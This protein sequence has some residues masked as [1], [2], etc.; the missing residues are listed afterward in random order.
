MK[1]ILAILSVVTVSS[2]LDRDRA[3]V[4]TASLRQLEL[5]IVH[6]RETCGWPPSQEEGLE[7]LV[8]EPQWWPVEVQWTSYLEIDFVPT[9]GWNNKLIYVLDPELAEGFGI[10]SCGRDGV[11]FS[12]GNDEADLNTWGRRRH[13][14]AYYDDLMTR[15]SRQRSV[16]KLGIIFLAI[17]AVAVAG[18]KA[19]RAKTRPGA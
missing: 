16:I 13:W 15:E 9:D 18:G 4:T 19:V 12:N 14:L 7:V 6:F 17:M 10:Y 5:G 11:S 3:M 8:H 1:A 2:H